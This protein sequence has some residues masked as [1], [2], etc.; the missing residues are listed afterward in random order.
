M[1][2][3][4]LP[5]GVLTFAVL[6][7]AAPLALINHYYCFDWIYHAWNIGFIGEYF[8]N[9]GSLPFYATTRELIGYPVQAFYGYL[10]YMSSGFLGRFVGHEVALR[11]ICVGVLALQSWLAYAAARQVS[12]S[13]AWSL[14]FS[15]LVTWATYPLTNLYNRGAVPEFVAGTMVLCAVFCW[16][17]ILSS[18]E[19]ATQVSYLAVLGV[20]LAVM[21]GTHPITTVYSTLVLFPI[22]LL[23]VPQIRALPKPLRKSLFLGLGSVVLFVLVVDAPLAYA[24]ARFSSDQNI[25]VAGGVAIYSENIDTLWTRLFP[26]PF[27]KRSLIYGSKTDAAYLDA[28]VNMPLLFLIAALA[29]FLRNEKKPIPSHTRT[30]LAYALGLA[31]VFTML[32]LWALPWKALPATLQLIQFGYRLITYINVALVLMFL[33]LIAA[34]GARA[35]EAKSS[36]AQSIALTACLVLG[37]SGALVKLG[38]VGAVKANKAITKPDTDKAFLTTPDNFPGENYSTLRIKKLER[39][40]G[41][42]LVRANFVIGERGEDYAQPRAL[43]VELDKDSW[44]VTNLAASSW[45][46]LKVDGKEIEASD[47]R[48]E[49]GRIAVRLEAGHH[50][51]EALVGADAVWLYLKTVSLTFFGFGILLALAL[52]LRRVINAT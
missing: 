15:C 42:P 9:H 26:L 12:G 50:R 19:R 24:L 47:L 43:Y 41:L 8:K 20:A 37:F 13:R 16:S 29:Y 31:V 22:L 39:P 17:L 25:A 7:V 28:Q 49:Q 3:K 4:Y 36:V 18:R 34:F 38:H 48:K 5:V 2:S 35:K 30:L 27:D 23:S 14:V 45:N 11:L 32:S 6:L 33:S 1:S 51:L 10:T 44:I 46:K 21:V 52:R 40:L